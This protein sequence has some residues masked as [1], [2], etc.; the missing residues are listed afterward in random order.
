MASQ[1]RLSIAWAAASLISATLFFF[2]TGLH[3][4]WWFTWLAPLPV[5][6]IATR[7]R[8][9]T[10]FAVAALAWVLGSLNMAGYYW[11]VGAIPNARAASALILATILL[12]PACAF[13]LAVLLW[14]TFARRD[15]LWL[16]ALALPSVWTAYEFLLSIS[17]PHGT[18]GSLAYTQMNF[19]PLLQLASVCGVAG[20]VFVLL[21]A[22]AAVAATGEG[23]RA[24]KS[25]I[26]FAAVTALAFLTVLGLGWWRLFSS[27]AGPTIQVGLAAS[28]LPANVFPEDPEKEG[29]L[30]AEYAAQARSLAG[31]GARA[32]VIPE[33]LGVVIA[34]QLAATDAL[35]QSVADQTGSEIVIGVVRIAANAAGER[36]RLNEARWY[37]P[38]ATV[39]TYE[40]H[41]MLPAFESSMVVGTTL[42]HAPHANDVWGLAICKDMDFPLLARQNAAAGVGL[43]LVPAWDFVD[44]AWLHDRMAILRGVESGFS[45]ARAAKQGLLTLSDNR[46]RVLAE[47]SSA[48]A[49]FASLVAAIPVQR[50][51]TWYARFGDWFAWLNLGLLA[52]LLV[53]AFRR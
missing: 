48:S 9:L 23:V 17:S 35:F 13:G 27:R 15:S 32:I 46:G 51:V 12:I 42:T 7:L 47:E 52:L 20:V 11:T 30:L 18:F 14:R 49:P 29:R 4:I 28:D 6:W 44:D 2:G 53:F 8:P 10:A 50:D 19:L 22:P 21:L 39:A 16:A 41:H 34:P 31:H 1:D 45:I 26:R 38:H 40:K 33:K 37:A 24:G 5:L 25:V 36:V 43:L 3:P